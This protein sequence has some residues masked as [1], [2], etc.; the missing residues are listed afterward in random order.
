[1]TTDK[2]NAGAP[3]MSDISD[4]ISDKSLIGDEPKPCP[5]CDGQA[6]SEPPGLGRSRWQVVCDDC[7]AKGPVVG[8]KDA[9]EANAVAA[10]NT[11]A[12]SA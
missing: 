3:I 11:R 8:R 12:R 10:W 4:D 2:Q 1:M 6:Y 9:D 7:G 5:F